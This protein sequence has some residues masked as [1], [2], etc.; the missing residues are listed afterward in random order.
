MSEGVPTISEGVVTVKPALET[1]K[2][3]EV[4]VNDILFNV[5][6]AS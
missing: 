3:G 5:K 1:E 4:L 2:L 6:D